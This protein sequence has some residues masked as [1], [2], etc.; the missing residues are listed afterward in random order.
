MNKIGL[1]KCKYYFDFDLLGNLRWKTSINRIKNSNFAGTL[2]LNG[3][4]VV[5]IENKK[6]YRTDIFSLEDVI[7]IRDEKLKEF[8]GQF[9]NIELKKTSKN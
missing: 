9:S 3:Y 5:G 1:E 7:K 6:Y 4:Y 2:H 8:H